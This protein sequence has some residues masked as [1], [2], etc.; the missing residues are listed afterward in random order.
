MTPS[1]IS[2][3][4]YRGVGEFEGPGTASTKGGLGERGVDA[5]CPA[6]L[7]LVPEFCAAPT[8][9]QSGAGAAT[10]GNYVGCKKAEM[11]KPI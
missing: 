7:V 2:N 3:Y 9:G 10:V 6:P 5:S 1:P 11:K 4:G 8:E